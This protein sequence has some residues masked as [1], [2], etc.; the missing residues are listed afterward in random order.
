M[1]KEDVLALCVAAIER[2]TILK[3]GGMKL[4]ALNS[5]SYSQA[6]DKEIELTDGALLTLYDFK[7]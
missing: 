5:K 3:D 4:Q 1:S 2:M 6:V 7:R